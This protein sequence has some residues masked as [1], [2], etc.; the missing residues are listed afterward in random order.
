MPEPADAHAFGPFLLL[1][2][3][4]V[5]LE[6]QAPVRI[7]QRAFEV[8][9]MLVE[10]HGQIVGKRA[11]LARAWPGLVVEEGN[12]KVTIA[13][14]RRILGE[15]VH[16]AAPRYIATVVGRGYRFIAPVRRE[17]Y[18]RQAPGNVPKPHH[19]I[20]GRDGMID[21]I[22]HDLQSARLV[23]IV[24]PG[25]VGKTT[26]ALAAAHRAGGVFK[27]GGRLVD[28]ARL[29]QPAQVGAAIAG[30]SSQRCGPSGP[31]TL[32]VL[33]NCE[34]LIGA[35]AL[36][37]DQLLASTWNVTCLVTSREPL[38]IRGERVRRLPGLGLPT[39]S[40][41]MPACAATAFPAVQLF[42][43][44]AA[45]ACPSFTLDDTNAA[46]VGAIC[47]RLD[48][49][50][51]AIERVAER[52]GTL[53]VASLLDH[54]DRRFHMF[55]GFHAGPARHRTLTATVHTSYT[56]LA[57]GERATLRR[58]AMFAGAFSLESAC[59]IC[60]A[61][62][63]ERAAVLEDIASLVA[64]SLLMAAPGHGEMAYRLP[65][66]T[67]AYALEQLREQGEVDR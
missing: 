47:Q 30:A 17:R 59:A 46:D 66:V 44:R 1:P 34:H 5:L 20:I 60:C 23:S 45:A 65:H 52:A 49:H 43:E 10:A 50:P 18:V 54:L 19:H 41:D 6:N 58:L 63:D 26:V 11:L 57:P 13:G 25:G 64:K 56:L 21:A 62:R 14:L 40:T 24:G 67:R 22:V 48:G 12:L 3:Q 2:G 16:A 7:G 27:D 29:A 37:V 38:C 31:A 55:D 33:D 42:A 8:L 9:A 53:G 28:L 51:L 4:A 32:I 36:C 39:D 15:H 61:D 35:V